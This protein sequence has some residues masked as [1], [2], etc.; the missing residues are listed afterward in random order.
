[1]V[2][3]EQW[4]K[5]EDGEL[6]LRKTLIREKSA[7][8]MLVHGG[9]GWSIKKEPKF[10]HAEPEV[11]GPKKSR[12]EPVVETTK[13]EEQSSDEVPEEKNNTGN[14]DEFTG[15]GDMRLD[16]AKKFIDTLDNIDKIGIII[17]NDTRKKIRDH[18]KG[19]LKTINKK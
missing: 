17:N 16:D 5:N 1:M 15:V 13:K 9:Q 11:K 18:A 10:S 3:V 8:L 7:A 12:V 2:K 4:L 19:R 14:T 6:T